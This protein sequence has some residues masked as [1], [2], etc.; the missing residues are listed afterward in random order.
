MKKSKFRHF[1]R[2]KWFQHVDEVTAWENK[3]VDYS[4]KIWYI[5]NKWFLANLYKKEGKDV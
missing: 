1:I 2:E 4:F 5:R 3:P